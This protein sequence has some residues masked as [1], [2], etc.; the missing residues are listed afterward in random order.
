MRD[1]DHVDA[2]R[3]SGFFEHLEMKLITVVSNEPQ[4]GGWGH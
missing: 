4:Y 3:T 2:M 1:G